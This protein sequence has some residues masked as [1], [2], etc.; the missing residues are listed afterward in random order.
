MSGVPVWDHVVFL[1][2]FLNA[3]SD[4]CSGDHTVKITC[5]ESK[6]IVRVLSGHRRTPWVV[7][8]HPRLPHILASGSLDHEVRVWNAET[9]HCMMK[10]TF[11]ACSTHCF[12]QV[13][14]PF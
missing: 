7:R 8:F 13:A 5:C 4:W 1:T 3:L 12:I 14:S 2:A 11:G 9:G 10:H 6:S